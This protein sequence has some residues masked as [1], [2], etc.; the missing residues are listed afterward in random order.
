MS[1]KIRKVVKQSWVNQK[2]LGQEISNL[3]GW[4][5]MF[6]KSVVAKENVLKSCMDGIMLKTTQGI[7]RNKM[8]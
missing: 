7:H 3:G 1:N 5:K 4:I 8:S 2:G 6:K